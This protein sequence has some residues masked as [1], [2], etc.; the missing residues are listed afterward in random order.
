MLC[1]TVAAIALLAAHVSS[2]PLSSIHSSQAA[3]HWSQERNLG[4]RT[5]S[6]V[7]GS[8]GQNIRGVNLG[9]WLVMEPWITPSIFEKI[10]SC[11]PDWN[12]SYIVVDEWTFWQYG[13]RCP[14]DTYKHIIRQHWDEWVL[15]DHLIQLAAANITHLRIPIGYWMF[16]IQNGEPFSSGSDLFPYALG[17][18]KQ[19]CEQSKA[20]GL[21]VL[22]DLHGAPGSQNGFD[23]SGRRGGIHILDNGNLDRTKMIIGELAKWVQANVDE[24]VVFGVEAVNEPFTYDATVGA[25]LWTAMRDDYY[26]YSYGAIR[27]ASGNSNFPQVVLQTAFKSLSDFDGVMTPAEGFYNV[28]LDDHNYQCFG[29]IN[30]WSYASDGWSKHL[31]Q[32]CSYNSYYANSPLWTFTGEFS[33]AVTDCTKWL[34]GIGRT[35]RPISDGRPDVCDFYNQPVSTI[36]ADYKQFLNQYARAQMD[37]FEQAGGWFFWNFRAEN[38]PEWDFLL[39][40]EM[41]WI[42]ANVGQ[43]E[44]FNCA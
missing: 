4:Y 2:A 15:E 18:L 29:D 16:D 32:A 9:G 42:P 33:L 31:K 41:G 13:P 14:G 44:P 35:P 24:D 5:R 25:A 34:D 26:P 37:A 8:S 17:R 7:A 6:R 19:V 40:L 23:N 43:R 22:F 28:W 11:Q 27:N 3:N 10:N 1:K 20:H 30:T 39:G 12:G 21:K 36:S 38:S